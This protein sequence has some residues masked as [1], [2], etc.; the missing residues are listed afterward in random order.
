MPQ[1]TLT[2]DQVRVLVG[3]Q[4]PLEVRDV[5]GALLGHFEPSLDARMIARV[6]TRCASPDRRLP[7]RKVREFLQT[8]DQAANN[9]ATQEQL[10]ALSQELLSEA[11]T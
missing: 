4:G 5:H 3:A 7:S 2:E 10:R 1:I 11:K 6:Q 8:L 9:G